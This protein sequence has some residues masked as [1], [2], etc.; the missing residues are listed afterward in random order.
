MFPNL[1]VRFA[2]VL[3]A[4]ATV[5]AATS[6]QGEAGARA[7]ATTG[8]HASVR[9]GARA[10]GEAEG[11]SPGGLLVSTPAW[12]ARPAGDIRNFLLDFDGHDYSWATVAPQY[13][14]IALNAWDSGWRAQ[15]HAASPAT[16]VYVYKS[17]IDTRSYD[18]GTSAG[19]GSSCIVGGKFCPAGVRDAPDLATGV[20]FCWAWRNH[21][22]W[23]LRSASGNLI[24]LAGY[25]GS[26]MMNFG[27]H[28]YQRAWLR[29]VAANARACRFGGVFADNAIT[30]T[31]YGVPVKYPTNAAIQSAMAS[32]LATVGPALQKDGLRIMPNLGYNN[33]Y[34]SL[35]GKWLR[36][37]SGFQDEFWGFWPGNGAQSGWYQWTTGMVKACVAQHKVCEFHTG[38]H[39]T[40]L[41]QAQRN[42]VTATLLLFTDGRQYIAYAGDSPPAPRTRLG[43]ATGAAILANNGQWT[44]HFA[45]GSVTVNPAD[46]GL[47]GT[48]TVR[49]TC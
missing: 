40:P 43:A 37:V 30:T 29:D 32:M 48:G 31:G 45:C 44:R 3:V 49:V 14:G 19:G 24:Q 1:T 23:F 21:P 20:G 5:F 10:Q 36:Y 47:H 9:A 42:Y 41:T 12:H 35:W 15:I 27:L 39:S 4:A 6:G 28:A 11:S 46:D 8:A 16:K 13:R 18:C 22:D 38:D 17:L 26:Y 7:P 25:P 34:P 2:A 33:L